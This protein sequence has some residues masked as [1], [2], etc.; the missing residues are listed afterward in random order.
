MCQATGPEVIHWFIGNTKGELPRPPQLIELEL[1]P[2]KFLTML[3]FKL[4]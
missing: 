3:F 2:G 1:E 4:S